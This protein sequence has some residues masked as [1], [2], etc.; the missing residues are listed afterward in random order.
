MCPDVSRQELGQL[1]EI[2][3][4]GVSQCGDVAD[5]MLLAS[6]IDRIMQALDREDSY[7][8]EQNERAQ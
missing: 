7:R 2:A 1:R 8:Q 5:K 6:L 3:R 4:E